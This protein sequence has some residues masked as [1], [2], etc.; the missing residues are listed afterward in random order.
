MDYY[1][2]FI[3]KSDRKKI[4][5]TFDKSRRATEPPPLTPVT[6][7]RKFSEQAAKCPLWTALEI[8]IPSKPCSAPAG[9]HNGLGEYNKEDGINQILHY[10]RK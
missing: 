2:Y 8:D 10:L 6:T 3:D 9:N 7:A 5:L 4:E 1:I